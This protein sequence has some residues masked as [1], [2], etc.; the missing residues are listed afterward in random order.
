MVEPTNGRNVDS[1]FHVASEVGKAVG[2]LV[3]IMTDDEDSDDEG[4]RLRTAPRG[5]RQ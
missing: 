5:C 4:Q 1:L 3:N 2:T